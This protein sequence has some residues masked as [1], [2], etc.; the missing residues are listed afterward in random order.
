[1]EL[2]QPKTKRDFSSIQMASSQQPKAKK[3]CRQYSMEYL[4][5]GFV[6]APNNPQI[7]LCLICDLTFSNEMMKPCKMKNHIFTKHPSKADKDLEYFKSLEQKRKKS[8]IVSLA[9]NSQ[10]EAGNGL[11]ASYNI[12]LLIAKAGKPHSIGE[13]LLV[14]VVQEVLKTVLGHNAP[15]QIIKS[16]PLSNDSVR[17]RVDEMAANVEE[18]LCDILRTTTFSLQIDESTLPGNESL[19]LGYVR[20]IEEGCV[21]EELLFARTIPTNKT[22]QEIFCVVESFFKEKKIPLSNILTCA[23]DGEAAMVGCHRGFLAYLKAAVP[24]LLTVH[25]VIHRQHLV[26]KNLSGQLH[27]TLSSVIKAVNKIKSKALNSRL[28]SQLCKENDELFTKLVMHT[29]VRWLSKGNCLKRFYIVYDSVIEFLEESDDNLACQLKDSKHSI[30]YLTDIFGEFNT[31]NK[32]LQGYELN[33]IRAKTVITMFMAKLQFMKLRL[34]SRGFSKFPCLSAV[35]EEFETSDADLKV[36]CDHLAS[37]H[38][39]MATRF[40]DLIAL[41]IPNWVLQPFET[42]NL[43][44]MET[45]E[46]DIVE[47]LIEIQNDCELKPM[48]SKSYQHFWLQKEIAIRYPELW[49]RVKILLIAF[50]TSYLVERGF[51]AVSQLLGK[52]RQKLDIVNRGDLRLNL[53][54]IKPDLEKIISQHQV[55]PAHGKP[56]KEKEDRFK[57]CIT[58]KN[59]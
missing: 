16:I 40:E 41:T 12:A 50:P 59:T 9:S 7:P 6:T 27:S 47:E 35:N 1:M 17:R 36:F 10:Q 2:Q 21:C 22:G 37:L 31:V 30:A 14:P 26:A 45:M 34:S 56:A 15:S 43:E 53:T 38:C 32:K 54:K 58:S 44:E 51:S 18:K 20:F 29:E 48:F 19:L 13:T 11:L 33:L 52:M 49:K 23:T 57:N 46:E 4:K 3:K 5:F 39:D 28:F 24:D 42:L 55:H 8:T 25:C